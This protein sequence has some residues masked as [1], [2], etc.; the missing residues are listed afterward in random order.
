MKTSHIIPVVLFSLCLFSCAKVLDKKDLTTIGQ[1]DLWNDP[2]LANAYVNKLYTDNLPAWDQ[3]VAGYSDEAWG[4]TDV[5]YGQLTVNSITT[6]SYQYIRNI[7]LLLQSIDKGTLTPAQRNPLKGQALFLR[8]WRYF[9]MTRLYGGVPLVLV[10]QDVHDSIFVP[11]N[12]TS[13]CISRIVTDLDSAAQL[14]PATWP[15]TDIGRVTAGAAMALKGRVLL[16]YA[17][18]QFNPDNLPDRWQKAYDANKAAKAFLVANGVGLDPDF[19]GLWFNTKTKEAVFQHRYSYPN[20]TNTWNAYTRPLDESMNYTGSNHP[21]LEMVRAFPMI[22]GRPITNPSVDHPYDTAHYWL[23]RDPRFNATIAY[24]GVVWELSGK[25]GRRQWTYSGGENNGGT[26]GF[27]CRKAV[28]VSYTPLLATQSATNWLEIR[29]AEVLLNLAECAN[30]VGKPDEAYTELIAIRQRAKILPGTDGLYGLD[31][32]LSG[33]A[34]TDAIM[35]ERQ[36]EFAY[37]G[38]RYHDLRRRRLFGPLLNGTSRHGLSITLKIPKADFLAIRDTVNLDRDYTNYFS[39][40]VVSLDTQFPI[41]F[42]DNYYFY[43]LSTANLQ[44]NA[45]LEQT[46]GW[47]NGTFDPLK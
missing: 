5:M 39:E 33:A 9:E 19:A 47:N 28:D 12:K 15:A 22:D 14:L 31:A 20:H 23:N 16:Y 27:Y 13:E 32:G 35:H 38:K 29:F 3:N 25:S 17:S 42:R 21:T 46:M 40:Q 41:N 6:W 4:G 30:E 18:P 8:A 43:A 45:K 7:N 24:N 34:M 37:E 36:I 2:L 44:S 10:A 11:R 1:N 26:N